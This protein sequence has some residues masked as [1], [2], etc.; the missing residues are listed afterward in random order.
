MIKS[1]NLGQK[2]Y[3]RIYTNK[4]KIEWKPEWT[5]GELHILASGD[6]CFS[7]PTMTLPKGEKLELIRNAFGFTN[8]QINKN[9]NSVYKSDINKNGKQIA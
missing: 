8:D 6:F 7:N 9:E 2:R 5:K 1:R 3:K 4:N